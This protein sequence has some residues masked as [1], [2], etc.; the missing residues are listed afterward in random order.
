[1]RCLT[2]TLLCRASTRGWCYALKV[3][4]YRMFVLLVEAG[5]SESTQGVSIDIIGNVGGWKLWAA[6]IGNWLKSTE[7]VLTT[8]IV[9]HKCKDNLN[10]FQLGNLKRKYKVERYGMKRVVYTIR[11][12]RLSTEISLT[13]KPDSFPFFARMMTSTRT[14]L[15]WCPRHRHIDRL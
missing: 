10:F 9:R 5:S 15:R 13:C 1:M 8:V 7:S 2:R 3:I 14:A 12:I 11:Y 6:L 4:W